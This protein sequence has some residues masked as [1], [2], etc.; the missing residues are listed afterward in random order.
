MKYVNSKGEE[1]EVST[2]NSEHLIN[3][4]AKKWRDTFTYTNKDDA[5]KNI[6]EIKG[7]QEELY[8]RVNIYIDTLGD[9]NGNTNTQK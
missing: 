7:L 1:L 9:N 3:A 5:Y 4:Y 6:N 2:M 8:K